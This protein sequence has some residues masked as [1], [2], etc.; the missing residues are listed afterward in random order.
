MLAENTRPIYAS[1]GCEIDLARRELRVLG[2]PVPVGGRAFEIIEVLVRSAGDLVTKDEL[3]NR[4]W[5]GAIVMENTLQVHAAAL[6]KALGPY[7]RLLKTESRRGYRLLGKWTVRHHDAAKPPVGLQ[8][9]PVTVEAPATNFPAT[10][11]RLV[12]RSAAV[13]RLQDLASA[14]RVVTLTGPGGIGKTTL[15]LEVARRVLGEF[16]AGGWL[17]ELAS[18]SDPDLVPSAV[19]GALGLRLGSNPISPEAVARAVAGRKLL[20]VLDNCEHVVDAAARLSESFLRLCP[21]ATILATSREVLR[22]EGE[23][24]YRV[25][26]LEVPATGRVDPA[27]ILDHSAPALFVARAKELGS[28]FSSDA[29]SLSTIAEICRHLDGI[30]LA[31]EFAAA[32]AAMLGIEPVAAALR[33]R[34]A[35]L[36]SGRRTALPRHRTLRATFDWSYQLL[37]ASEQLLLRWLSVFPSAFSLAAAIEILVDRQ[38][39]SSVIDGVSGLVEKS[40]LNVDETAAVVAYRMLETTREYAYRRLSENGEAH[41][42]AQRHALYVR[43]A[44]VRTEPES[45]VS[46]AEARSPSS[47]GTPRT[48]EI[49]NVR[50][51]LDWCF[52]PGGDVGIG[53]E[54][55]AAYTRTWLYM[56]LMTECRARVET[57]LGRLDQ[58][59]ALT[60]EQIMQ[61]YIALSIAVVHTTGLVE[62][63]QASL[64]KALEIADSTA[65][66]TARL[67]AL[68]AIWDYHS[69]SREYTRAL[70]TA[71]K[72]HRMATRFG[73]RS[74]I[75]AANR[76]AGH[77]LHYHGEQE[78]ARLHLEQVLKLETAHAR[79]RT[80]WFQYDQRVLAEAI[81]TRVLWL[82]GYPDKAAATAEACCAEAA[83]LGYGLSQCYAHAIAAF[84][85]ACLIGN[86]AAA[87]QA[88][89][90]CIR[91]ANEHHLSFYQKWSQCLQ[92]ALLVEQEDFSAGIAALS[93]ALP[94][95]GRVASRQPEFQ[96]ALA[97]GLAGT[98]DLARALDVLGAALTHAKSDGEYW[99]V[100]EL[101]RI[102]SEIL[103]AQ[104]RDGSDAAERQLRYALRLARKQGA[105]SWELRAATSLARYLETRGDRRHESHTVLETVVD[106]FTEGFATTDLLT[107]R[108]WLANRR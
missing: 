106:Q 62:D 91:V 1:G 63:T 79:V 37:P 97:R 9:T 58:T 78:T 83:E 3:M 80:V 84:P 43:N 4:I 44:I 23:Y 6:R 77:S 30:P 35:L 19:A 12:G 56:S 101:L 99:C 22:I 17:V 14:Y 60:S 59:S 64:E 39:R 47:D 66:D 74:A 73:D 67:R 13:Q 90:A 108:K 104:D 72:F 24:A 8:Q 86:V 76:L 10:V 32:R 69:N 16:A 93:G 85:L 95:L 57:A 49:H 48:E 75:V 100:P 65:D 52:S 7:R 107:A 87:E 2:S 46:S 53:L 61:L 89:D 33:D 70:H 98:G 25:A 88:L 18:L 31:I 54:I 40:L 50:A 82:L 51:A 71:R 45:S 81:L 21:G 41:T 5:P 34:F 26:S 28:D 55:T 94:V 20:L 92:G 11:T 15:A 68:W 36:T 103:I 38:A 27:N 96:I 29:E 105:R 42:A 102:R